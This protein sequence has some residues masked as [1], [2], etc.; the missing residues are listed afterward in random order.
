MFPSRIYTYTII[1]ITGVSVIFFGDP[2]Q[3]RPVKRKF[4]WEAPRNE[5][6]RL[7]NLAEGQ[8]DEH[9][10]M[11]MDFKPIMLKTNHRQGDEKLFAEVLNRVR[12]GELTDDDQTLMKTRVFPEDCSTIPKGCI[13]IFPTNE[14]VNKIN[15]IALEELEGE[16]FTVEAVVTHRTNQN[17]KAPVENTGN[18]RN[19]NLQ[20]TLK[21]KINSKILITYNLCTA[22]G[23]TNG[24]FGEVIDVQMDHQ[25]NIHTILVHLTN[26]DAGKE[27]RIGYEHLARKYHKPVIPIRKREQTFSLDK[28]GT[29]AASATALQFPLK[30]A[31]AGTSHKLQGTTV[32]YPQS[33][34]MDFQKVRSDGQVYVMLSRAQKLEQL[35][36]LG[37]LHVSKWKAS[38]SALQELRRLER[39]ALNSRGIGKFQIA[40]LNVR[41]LQ[42]HYEDIKKLINFQV[43]VIC[44]QE[45]WISSDDCDQDYNL[46]GMKLNLNSQGR[47]KGI[48]TY[49]SSKYGFD[50][51]IS[52]EDL[53]MTKISSEKLDVIN[54]YRSAHNKTLKE[55]IPTL[56][57]P[58]KPTIICG[59]INCDFSSEN[60]DF[61]STLQELGFK[62]INQ[63]PTHDEGRSIDCILVNG[64]LDGAVTIRQFGVAFSDHDCFLLKIDLP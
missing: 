33:I 62:K 24:S 6:F 40:S 38:T 15:Q 46:P 55:R 1:I 61:L 25:K 57:D 21:F 59:D 52:D 4:P 26:P 18:I 30:L 12:V 60:P 43:D 58:D 28:M 32:E 41:S 5:K 31:T 47:G 63:S 2:L 19:T 35:Y 22:D 8:D 34:A 10:Q 16:E 54:I 23:I 29:S 45:T 14:E 9:N 64:F 39:K 49:C 3:L 42:K 53:Q 7:Y 17:F 36:I 50:G 27:T 44:L 48:A 37:D 11:W 56:V 51:R 20:K 13:Y